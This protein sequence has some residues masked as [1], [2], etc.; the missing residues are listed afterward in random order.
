MCASLPF[1][2]SAYPLPELMLYP[3]QFVSL[4]PFL[5]F[6]ISLSLPT[7][8]PLPSK[9][10]ARLANH[11]ALGQ[12]LKERAKGKIGDGYLI[13]LERPACNSKVVPFL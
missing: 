2:P 10:G 7:I 5:W 6:L 1:Q 8:P 12:E 13:Q 9:V 3:I 4:F 11:L